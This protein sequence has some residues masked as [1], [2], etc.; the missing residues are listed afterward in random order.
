V[1]GPAF[2]ARTRIIRA[3]R[4]AVARRRRTE[5]PSIERFL[6]NHAMTWRSIAQSFIREL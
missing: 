2:A 3:A 6:P 1:I 5:V 4:V